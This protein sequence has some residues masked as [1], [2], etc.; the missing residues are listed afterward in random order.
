MGVV[1][2]KEGVASPILAAPEKKS[3]T[4]HVLVFEPC[5]HVPV[6]GCGQGEFAA[7]RAV[8]IN[9]SAGPLGSKSVWYMALA[10]S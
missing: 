1:G 6:H 3:L 5:I 7:L 10:T 4:R 8:H 9:F 2:T